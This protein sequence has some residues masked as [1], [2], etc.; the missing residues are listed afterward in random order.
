[1]CIVVT[2]ADFDHAHVEFVCYNLIIT[3][4]ARF[5]IGNPPFDRR[6]LEVFIVA[7]FKISPPFVIQLED[8]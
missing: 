2:S 5:K 8:S 1:V 4:L 3:I 7:D 6:L